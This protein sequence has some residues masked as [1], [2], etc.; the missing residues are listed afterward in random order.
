M[1]S[2]NNLISRHSVYVLH[3]RILMSM[4]EFYIIFAIIDKLHFFMK[5]FTK[6]MFYK[7]EEDKGLV[8]I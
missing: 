4:I 6:L 2:R 7:T 8:K 1:P 5:M 3:I